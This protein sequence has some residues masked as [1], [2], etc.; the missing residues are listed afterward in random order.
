MARRKTTSTPAPA[1][2]RLFPVYLALEVGGGSKRALVQALDQDGCYVGQCAQ[3]MIARA[4]FAT[5]DSPRTIKLARVQLRAL[6]FTDWVAWSDVLKAATKVGAEK[7]PAEAAARLRLDLP[8]QQPGDHF[9]ILM[10]PIIGPDG[11]PYV[12]YLASHDDGER[13][14]LGRYVSSSRRFF[15]HREI[16]FGLPE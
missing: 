2:S 10:D 6:G 5:A 8:D 1:G 9:W 16:V 15:P 12:F 14:L 11:E 3:E 4:S 13:R 7:L